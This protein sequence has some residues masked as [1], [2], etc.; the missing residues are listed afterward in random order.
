MPIIRHGRVTSL[1]SAIFRVTQAAPQLRAL[2]RSEATLYPPPP[3]QSTQTCHDCHR[4]RQKDTI[5][6]HTN[7]SISLCGN[8]T[9][10]PTNVPTAGG[11][12]STVTP[13]PPVT[14]KAEI[15]RQ[16]FEDLFD[17]SRLRRTAAI[18]RKEL[19]VLRARD[20]IDWTDW[21]VALEPSLAS[22]SQEVISGAYAP[23]PPT[24][25]ELGKSHGAFRVITAFNMRD[26]IVY[27]HIC[28][29]ALERATAEKV[30]GAYFRDAIPRH[31]SAI[32]LIWKAM[33]ITPFLKSGLSSIST[34]LVLS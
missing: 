9:C 11:E 20:V 25:Y 1:A 21:F 32:R 34:V 30:P 23:S 24:R 27:R 18:I 33:S 17:P 22:L 6:S 7:T 26:A 16:T 12:M 10:A 5:Q 8:W 19:R 15:Q 13:A 31:R 2:G 14:V 28:D 29:E 3:A 4:F